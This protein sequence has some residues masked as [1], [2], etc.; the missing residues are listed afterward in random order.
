M[1]KKNNKILWFVIAVVVIITAI[2]VFIVIKNMNEDADKNNVAMDNISKSYQLLEDNIELYN[3]NRQTL[4]SS[5]DNYY[6]DNLT[7]DYQT[8]ITL[9]SE[10]ADIIKS[11]HTQINDIEENC[12]DRIFS[13]KEINNICSNYQDYYEMVVNIFINDKQEIN[14]II[15]TYNMNTNSPL[16]E[17]ASEDLTDYID[18]NKDGQYLGREAE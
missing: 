6:T 1:K 14:K 13:K 2:M 16:N 9:L 11:I 17:Y 5:L 12:Q 4:S 3:N 8:Y 10:Q 15:K 7:K 18:Y